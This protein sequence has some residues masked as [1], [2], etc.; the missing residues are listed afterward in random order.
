[1]RFLI[2]RLL[3]HSELGMFHEYRKQKK[4][5]SRQRAINFDGAVVDRVFPAAKDSDNI[6]MVLRYVTDAGIEEKRQWL[7]R[8]DKNWRLEGNCPE[9][10]CYSFVESGCLFAMEIHAGARPARGAWAVFPR[11]SKVAAAVLAEGESSGLA[12]SA[13]IALY[14]DE[15]ARLWKI[16][17]EAHSDLFRATGD[18][19]LNTGH[20]TQ[21]ARKPKPLPPKPGRLVAGVSRVGH[22]LPSAVADLVDN[23]IS[24]DATE[25]RIA[26]GRPDGGHGR[27]ISITDNGKGMDADTLDEAMRLGG[28]S[29]YDSNSLGKFGFGLK[30]ASWS[31]TSIF[32]VVTR[33]EGKKPSHLTWDARDMEEWL[34]KT[35]A[36]EAWEREATHIEKHGTAVLWKEMR[37]PESMPTVRGLEPYTA[38]VME[39]SR[40]LELV[41]HRFLEG[42][43]KGR[44]RLSL[45]I[46]G[47]P[48]QPNNPVGHVLVHSFDAK[49]IK[50]PT[51]TGDVKVKAQAFLLP[52]EE[53]LEGHH[54][55][56]GQE[57][58]RKA[59]EKIGLYGKRNE[60]QG[61]FIYRNDRLIKWGG[62]HD[63]W[64][65]NDEKTK[66]ARVIVDLTREL[67]EPFKINISKRHV[68]L[69]QQLQVEIKKLA[70]IARKSSQKKYRKKTAR[71]RME[72]AGAGAS[73][74]SG[75]DAR[76]ADP[77]GFCG[78]SV[79][80]ADLGPRVV[81]KPVKTGKF[82]WKVTTGITGS[83][84]IQVS[85]EE[86]AL[87]ALVTS[88]NRVP[89]ALSS[90]ADFLE[91]LDAIHAQQS[92]R[93]R[94]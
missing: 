73:G 15:G 47:T 28:E 82:I 40:H 68:Q 1:M 4:E 61:L 55:K 81:L 93:K 34:P 69:P 53:E 9:D 16:L 26:F 27:W 71:I 14:A 37:P 58:T 7:K 22:T 87:L 10:H 63:I 83:K 48:V 41:F 21:A 18:E 67:D 20:M 39:L 57:A 46:N 52:S 12:K 92:L 66:L 2:L 5:G 86:P 25:I 29:E 72:S 24:A 8:Q 85:E 75:A 84:E 60:S 49:T 59:L 78:G 11:D 80:P 19:R 77:S 51:A 74:A 13:M 31:Q 50:I 94:T 38:E 89:S 43:A 6:E 70:E 64:S 91:R 42:S 33:Q 56:D 44:K 32:T 30:S 54:K 90:L 23:A 79:E 65:T 3:T 62:W 36:L 17:E 45:F 88:I 35:T 76:P